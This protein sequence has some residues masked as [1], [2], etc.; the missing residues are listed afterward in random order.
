MNDRTDETTR[1]AQTDRRPWEEIL[2]QVKKGR[3][4]TLDIARQTLGDGRE[5]VTYTVVDRKAQDER[6]APP[7]RAESPR[8]AHRFASLE[9][10]VD[11]LTRY[12]TMDTT[13]WADL[14][15]LVFYGVLDERALNGVEVV[16]FRPPIDPSFKPWYALISNDSGS[17]N[18]TNAFDPDC[19]GGGVEIAAFSLFVRAHRRIVTE[20]D[21]RALAL[22]LGQITVSETVTI[23]RG[24]G[25]SSVNGV[26]CETTIAGEK[27]PHVEAVELPETLTLR[28]P[29]FLGR[30]PVDL[31][32]DLTVL[33]V[34]RD[35]GTAVYVMATCPDLEALVAQ[36]FRA[37]LDGVTDRIARIESGRRT[38]DEEA[39]VRAAAGECAL[40][41]GPP[42]AR[43]VHISASLGKPRYLP[44]DYVLE[45][46]RPA[47]LAS[48]V[49]D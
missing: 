17:T 39:G 46:A 5:A 10:F 44:W 19:A 29:L 48:P 11:W 4:S 16:S 40:S 41:A 12:G 21:P 27:S 35:T 45:H 30:D 8:R 42:V 28:T 33:P 14:D 43:P 2:R 37:M 15:G 20:P 7:V 25:V 47:M 31:T 3:E 23:R 9:G 38:G 36:E 24:V 32:V 22:R 18:A 13:V 26:M 6:P 49:V 34:K 1:I